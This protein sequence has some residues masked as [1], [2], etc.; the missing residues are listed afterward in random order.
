MTTEPTQ[1]NSQTAT[2]KSDVERIIRD[3]MAEVTLVDADVAIQADFSQNGLLTSLGV[4]SID[5][6]ELIV[7]AEE[8]FG[9]EFDDVEL[10]PELVDPVDKLVRAICGK[11]GI[12]AD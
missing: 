2:Q 3:L 10:K 1:N 9:F 4:T 12:A 7:S 11:L 5:A 8:R 6:F